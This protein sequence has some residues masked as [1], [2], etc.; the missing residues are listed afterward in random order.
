MGGFDLPILFRGD[1]MLVKCKCH[2]EKIDRDTAF[3]VIIN[4]KN[5]YY[6]TEKDYLK[7]KQE[8]ENRKNL[9]D[10]INNLFG[11]IVTNTILYKEISELSKIYPYAKINSYIN[12]NSQMLEKYMSKSFNNE[13]GKIKYFTTIIK[14]N[15]KDYVVSK[16]KNIKQSNT[17]IVSVIYTPKTRK[18]SM[19]EYLKELE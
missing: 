10:N 4:N 12:D 3:K 18:K 13:Y 16:P 19:D 14:N 17:E 1:A 8:K 7:I 15:I 9:F 6:C 2:S 5:E 11:Y